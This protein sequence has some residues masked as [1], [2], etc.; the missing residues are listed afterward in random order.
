[1]AFERKK[2]RLASFSE[3]GLCTLHSL[4]VY[5]NALYYILNA[6]VIF[7]TYH[8]TW[9]QLNDIIYKSLPSVYMSVQLSFIC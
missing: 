7:C 6:Y 8:G 4:C 1:M 2:E 3:V 5:A 9:T